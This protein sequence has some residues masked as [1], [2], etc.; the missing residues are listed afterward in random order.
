MR[1]SYFGRLAE[2]AGARSTEMSL[3]PSVRDVADLRA[4][5]R[6]AQPALADA[7][8]SRSVRAL[9]D[10]TIVPDSHTMADVAEVAFLPPVSGG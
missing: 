1:I 5:I 4:S 2:L 8:S 9:I 10:D 6:Q 7:M 3:P